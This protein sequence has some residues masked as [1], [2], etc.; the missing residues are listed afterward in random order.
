VN[1][2]VTGGAGFIGS[3]FVRLLL[4]GIPGYEAL[5]N[6]TVLDS[7]TY[8]GNLENLA[9]VRADSRLRILTQSINDIDGVKN[10]VEGQ[11]FIFNFAAESHVDRS[12]AN[13]SKFMQ[14]N[15]LGS[16]N[17]FNEALRANVGRVVHISTDE[18][19]GSLVKGS[20]SENS[21]LEPNSP[22]AASKASSD[23]IARSFFQTHKLPIIVTRC[24]NNYGPFQN[25]EKLVPLAITNLIMGK[26][27][28]IYGSGKNIR[29][30]IHV[31]DHCRAIAFLAIS[32]TP[33]EIYN[34]G[35][36]N[37]IENLNLI[38]LLL[39]FME[40]DTS[41]IEHVEDRKGHD[42]RYALDDSKLLKLGFRETIDFHSGILQTIKWYETNQEW[43]RGLK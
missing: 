30:W 13:A 17:I 3:A 9:E 40:L 19:Y 8:S 5:K 35:G 7:L 15:I 11:D 24:S 38:E 26:N 34:I 16:Y 31:D 32:G 4:S 28:P 25:P 36:L 27:V 37:A 2:L 42:F 23:L 20:A 39:G 43:W 22:Y 6:I 12:I 21:N 1:I 29:E 10:A 14:T 18:V 41:R 33:G